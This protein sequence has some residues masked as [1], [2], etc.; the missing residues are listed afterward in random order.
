INFFKLEEIMGLPENRGDVFLAFYWGGAMIGRFLGAVS[1]SKMEEGAKKLALMAGIALAAFG[2][3]YLAALTKSK[4]E[5]EFTQVL[6]FLLLIALNLGGFIL[7]RSMPGRT[8]AVFA[9]VNLVLLVFTIFAGGP[10]AFWTAIGIGLF[11]SIM[12]SNIFTL[13]IDGLGKYTSQGSSLLVMMILGG[14]VIPPLQGLLAD[15]I[16]L[17]PSFSLALLCYGYLFYYGALGY[18][19]GKPAPVG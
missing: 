5:L 15:T 13:S 14:A 6:P 1:L 12:W 17:Q 19:R 3:I 8:L 16:G 10:L 9:G 4:F 18:K 2:V 11:N 7:G